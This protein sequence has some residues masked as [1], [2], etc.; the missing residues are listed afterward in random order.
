MDK[1]ILAVIF[2]IKY[3]TQPLNQ[4][5]WGQIY[6]RIQNLVGRALE[7]QNGAHATFYLIPPERCG[8]ATWNQTH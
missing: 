7:K 1:V 2:S 4:N 3:S 8:V 5:P 6:L